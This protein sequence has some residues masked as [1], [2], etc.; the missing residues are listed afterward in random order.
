M[1]V[2]LAEAGI[3]ADALNR[4]RGVG[5]YLDLEHAVRIGMFPNLPLERFKQVGNAAGHGAKQLLVSKERRHA[6]DVIAEKIDYVELTTYRGF[7]QMYVQN[8][9][10]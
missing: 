7:D 10:L 9:Y 6:A 5:L 2:L 1:E 8:M 4:R 3:K